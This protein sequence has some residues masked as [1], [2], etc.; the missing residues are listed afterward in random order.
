MSK[1]KSRPEA[2]DASIDVRMRGFSHRS[3][4]SAVLSWID[5]YVQPTAVEDIEL[6]QARGRVLASDITSHVDV[7]GFDRAM[8]DGFALAADQTVGATAYHPLTLDVVGEILPASTAEIRLQPGQAVR[9]MTGAPIPAGADAVL[10]VEKTQPSGD[11]VLVLDAIPPQKNIGRRG[12]DV[13]HG[14]C[15]LMSGRRLRPQ[16]IGVLSSIG[17]S[18]VRV[19]RQPR[20][21]IVITGNELL[22]SGSRPSGAKIVDANGPML[23]ALVE[24]DGGIVTSRRIVQDS[25]PSILEAM[26]D[27]VDIVIISGGSS[28]GI[29]DHAPTLLAEHGELVFHGLAM[30]PSSPTGLGRL[31]DRIVFLLPGNPV[32]CLC[33]YDFFA[34]RAIRRL[35]DLSSQWPYRSC[36]LPL[37][38]KLVSQVGRVDYARVKRVERAVE[39]LAIS[40]ASILTSTTRADGFVVI[41]EDSEGFAE[42]TEIEVYLYDE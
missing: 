17:V 13:R 38:R 30:R 12:E 39:P 3:T 37:K 27:D 31:G 6:D 11:Q 23:A 10:P 14:D 2:H 24:R 20:V 22:P 1:S 4:V 16:D 28:V 15:V 8:M 36:Q 41:P 35:G 34:G 19:R 29:E 18:R 42:G 5:Q 26:G 40:G 7:P 33:A 21:R 9:I 25:R 32:S